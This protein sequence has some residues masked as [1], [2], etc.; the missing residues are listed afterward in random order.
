MLVPVV[1]LLGVAGGLYGLYKS[2]IA[3]SGP[4]ITVFEIK[5]MTF[6]VSLEAKG[7]IKAETNTEVRCE[8]EGSSTIVWLIEEGKQVKKG[9]LLVELT[10]QGGS[11]GSSIEDRIKKQEIAV[12][13]A[14]AQLANADKS[15]E[16]QLDLNESNIRKAELAKELAELN[17][18]KYIEGDA[19]QSR[20]TTKLAVKE[21]KA[22]LARAEAEVKTN[23]ELIKRGYI[24]RTE[25]EDDQFLA[26]KARLQL[27]RAELS[28]KILGE[29]T[30][31][32]LMRT[33]QSTVDEAE[34]DLDR[35]KKYAEAQ[36]AQS[37]ASLDA[38]RSESGIQDDKLEKL[39][40]QK[41]NLKITAPSHGM[42][43]Y[44][45]SRRY[46]DSKQ[47]EVGATVHQRQALVD[48][49]DP[50]VIQV[51]VKINESKMDKLSLDLPATIEVE[52]MTDKRF[53]GKVTKIGVL[54][55]A[56]HRWLN[57]NLKEFTNEITLDETH[58][59]LK[60]GMTATVEI[61]VTQLEDVLAVPIQCVYTKGGYSFVFLVDGKTRYQ[62]VDLG[63]ASI[64]YVHITK[65]LEQGNQV[66]LVITEDM[67]RL[68]PTD[69][70]LN[71]N[72]KPADSRTLTP[73]SGMNKSKR[74]K[75]GPDRK[76]PSQSKTK[77]NG[78]NK[79]TS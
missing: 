11:S 72:G 28:E 24:T 55:D 30:E 37:K 78:H 64:E 51:E 35:A 70:G 7:E 38:K 62:E 73:R 53:T 12:A 49:P 50:S 27:Q 9:D 79:A 46:W 22:V 52:G 69:L 1:A 4:D 45:R 26:L 17:L 71:G 16:I 13:N 32:V 14:K 19:E 66:S 59:D 77:T 33:R 20:Q 67:K 68:L 40:R 42:V 63:L 60:P 44:H 21:S 15:H 34:K 76:A 56:Q 25:Y 8:V 61:L 5:P 3:D 57:P 48:L 10:N 65:G 47:V 39:V 36:A 6:P 23:E 29:Y 75:T 2:R 41:G 74:K 54:A 58:P 43:V 18:N 31:K